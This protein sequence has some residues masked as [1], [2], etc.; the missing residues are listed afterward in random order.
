MSLSKKTVWAEMARRKVQFHANED[1][2]A[3]SLWGLFDWGA[4]S[5]MLKSGELTTH[6]K[7]E[8][9]TVWVKPG[10]GMYEKHIRPLIEQHSLDELTKLSGWE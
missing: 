2:D 10:A 9:R 1:P 8:N 6:M 5:H 3:I 7:K 4:V